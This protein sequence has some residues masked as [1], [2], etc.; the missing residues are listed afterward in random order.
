MRL[1]SEVLASGPDGPPGLD[2][3]GPGAYAVLFEVDDKKEISVGR[4]G[5]G[6][7]PAG[8]YAYVGS[9]M[10]GIYQR[11]RHHL[12]PEK[13]PR[14]HIDYLLPH[15]VIADIVAVETNRRVECG[16]TAFMAERL[17]TVRRFG[18]SD[19]TCLGHL[20]HVHDRMCLLQTLSDA[21]RSVGCQPKVVPARLL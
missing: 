18:S 7:Y 16:L 1:G 10:S 15:A 9:A 2:G 6:T 13:K 11:V 8:W 3:L 21:A 14:W 4:L 19:C 12:R 20:F 17:H 5:L